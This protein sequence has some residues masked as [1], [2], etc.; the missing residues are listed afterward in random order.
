VAKIHC[1]RTC[2]KVDVSITDLSLKA[3]YKSPTKIWSKNLEQKA[4]D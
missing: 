3:T 1:D 4:R 2:A